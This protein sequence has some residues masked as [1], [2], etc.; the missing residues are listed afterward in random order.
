MTVRN[1]A[2]KSVASCVSAQ[3]VNTS[4]KRRFQN[5]HAFPVFLDRGLLSRTILDRLC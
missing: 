3:R 2:R 1:V 5:T 4:V